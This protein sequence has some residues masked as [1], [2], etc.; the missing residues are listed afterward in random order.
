M[1]NKYEELTEILNHRILVLD[2]A[3]GTMI[4][5]FGLKE[6]DF[7]GELF[8]NSDKNLK[9]N[10]DILVLTQPEIIRSI[11][12]QYLEA[13]AD[14]IETDT[15]NANSISQSDYNLQDITYQL[16]FE[17]AKLAKSVVDEF[18]RLNPEKPRFVSGSIGPTNQTASMPSDINNPAYR[19]FYFDDFVKAYTIQINGLIDGGADILQIE[20]IFD[21]LNCKAAIFAISEIKKEL[22]ISI[23]VIISGTITDQSGR[24]LSGQTLEAFLISISH[25]PDLL[26]IGLNCSLGTTQLAPFIKELS[27]KSGFFTCIYP[28]AGLPNPFGDYDETAQQMTKILQEFAADGLINIIGGC[29]GTTPEH[30]KAIS[31]LFKDVPPRKIPELNNYLMVSGLEPLVL[32]PQLNFVNIGER[33]NVS[34]SKKFNDLIIEEKYEEALKVARH[35]VENGA[36]IIDINVDSGLQDSEKIMAN[37][38]N[39]ISAEPDISKIPI[40][41]DSSKWSVIESGLKCIQGKGIVNS[42]SLKEGPDKFKE[43][44]SKAKQ[45]GA[46]VI[47]MAFDEEGQATSLERKTEILSRSYKILTEEI[48]FNPSDIIFDPNILAIATGMSEHND[49]AINYIESVTWLKK[50]FPLSHISGGISNLSFSFRSNTKIRRAINSVFLYHAIKAGLD[51]GILNPA[52][53]EIYDQIPVDVIE[54]IENVIFNKHENAVEELTEYAISVKDDK[55]KTETIVS[56][57]RTLDI[58]ERLKFSIINGISDFIDEDARDALASF[59]FPLEIIEKPLMDGI[60]IV[61]DMFGS[62]KMFL[63]QVVKSA[64]VMKKYV[65]ILQPEI[66][67]SL[68][69]ESASSNGKILLATV[70]GDVHDIGKNIVGVV[71]SC[72]NY[73]IVDLGVM[74]PVEKIIEEIERIKPD[75]VGFSGLI[76]P[77]LDEMVNNVVEF[78]KHHINIPVL[79]GGA[80]TSKAHT[81]IKIAPNYSNPVIYVLDASRAVPVVNNLMNNGIKEEFA[82]G[83]SSEYDKIRESY[84]KA[85]HEKNLISFSEARELRYKFDPATA[86]IKK[87]EFLGVKALLDFPL[88]RLREYIN[89]T[90]FFLAWELKDRYP[91]IFDNP[92]IGKEAKK[93]YDEA[94]T[95]LDELIEKK[96]ISANSVFGLFPA[97]SVS[98]D[99]IEIYSDESH[100]GI[101]ATIHNLRQQTKRDNKQVY[102]SL[103]DFIAPKESGITDYFGFFAVSAGFGVDDLVNSYKQNNDDYSAIMIKLL[104]DRLAEAFAEVLHD[105]VRSQYWGYASQEEINPE[106]AFKQD[107]RGIRPAPGYPC[108]PDHSEK[109]TL[110]SLLQVEKNTGISLTENYMMTPGA[111]VCGY[112]LAHPDSHYFTVGKIDKSQILD[113]KTRKGIS[114]ERAEKLLSNYLGY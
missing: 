105:D 32:H 59:D 8:K 89:W 107:Y 5:R 104:A 63:P 109:E 41:I 60:K 16:N 29:C 67:K 1:I 106:T 83:I 62:G 3:M 50:H 57:W 77:S 30:I 87:P 88:N 34:G 93:L 10:N 35:Q 52:D 51:M 47:V 86:L 4:Q 28:N 14:I 21:T 92:R 26:A 85:Q 82:S 23:P 66:E 95:M 98:Y 13:G 54:K 48:G 112:Y 101:L 53:I 15:F 11:H 113:Y 65:A 56:E 9:G 7:R 103:S 42:I 79:I 17:A 100:R 27:R 45:Y 111:S 99:D 38:L 68:K 84:Y 69:S 36:Q 76:T 81:A 70:K 74:V 18:T 49:Y 72:N 46:A 73:E 43:Y 12:R 80:T 97:N 2:G 96:L 24:T 64:R 114:T 58:Y 71:L 91:K 44:A 110:F 39:Q 40:M 90:E 6:E 78:E 61:G 22:K 31:E 20:T 33:T 37:Y 55:S 94:N 108:L 19:K 75:I 102:Y 25:C